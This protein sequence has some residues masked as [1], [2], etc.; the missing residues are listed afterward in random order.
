MPGPDQAPPEIAAGSDFRRARRPEQRERRRQ[1]ILDAAAAMLAEMPVADISLRELSRR[2]GLAG[3]NV[4]RYFETREG[5]FLALLDALS[6]EWLDQL[7][8][9]LGADSGQGPVNPVEQ[10]ARTWARSLAD[11]PLIC[12]LTSVLSGVLERNVSVDSVREF[13]RRAIARNV[14]LANLIRGRL[15]DLD[16]R[17]ALETAS[18]ATTL[19]AGLWPLANP[20]PVVRAATEDPELAAAHVDF[21]GR[22]TRGLFLLLAGQLATGEPRETANQGMAFSNITKLA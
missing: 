21:T 9:D 11:R 8:R 3:S 14:R 13:K 10:V 18:L 16:D 1:A 12:E 17:A 19:L 6:D 15:S 4:L 7:E 5:V 2:V 22:M 20:G